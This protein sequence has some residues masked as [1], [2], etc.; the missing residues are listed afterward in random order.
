MGKISWAVVLIFAIFSVAA[1]VHSGLPPSHDGEYHVIRFYE[2]NRTF[3]SGNLYPRWAPDLNFGFG[4]PLFNYNY[5]L[6]NFVSTFLHFFGISFIDALKINMFGASILG[7]IFFYLWARQFW[8]KLGGS[9]SSVFYTFSPYHFLDIYIRGSVG[10]VW[11]LAFFPAFLWSITRFIRSKEKIFG[12]VSSIFLSLIIF[13]H[14]ILSLMFLIFALS[15]IGFLFFESKD[16]KMISSTF[17]VLILGISIST[18]FWLPAVLEQKF[19]VGLKIFNYS[20]NFVDLYQLIIPSWGSGFSGG[21]LRDTI[22]LQIGIANLLAVIL[23][24][25]VLLKKVSSKI[26][27]T[28]LF[29]FFWF[30]FLIFMMLQASLP[31]WKII[32]LMENFQFPWRFLSLEILICSFLAGSVVYLFKP[33]LL[34]ILMIVLA[35]LLGISYARPAYYH[36]RSDSYYVSRSNFIDGTNSIGNVFNTIWAKNINSRAPKLVLE[37]G[38]GKLTNQ[39]I[40]ATYYKF[41][42][43]ATESDKLI[44]NTAYFPGWTV[45]MDKRKTDFKIEEK[46]NFSIAVPK[47]DHEFVVRFEETPLRNLANLITIFSVFFVLLNL[48]KFVR[49]KK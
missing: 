43:R 20:S 24:L 49:I 30:I 45:Y 27:K 40:K 42:V 10:E 44:I 16:K 1:L 5:P 15:Y 13:S 38:K 17:L 32:P 31:V 28:I 29:S 46:G 26:K 6:P 36:Q 11:A 23:S 48:F 34:A 9:V 39:T 35:F 47:G 14:N 33:I 2:F 3:T 7:G 4:V 37:N 8:G 22:S 19:A 18:I 12:A 41:G 21:P 25:F